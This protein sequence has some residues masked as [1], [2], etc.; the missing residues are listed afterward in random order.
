MFIVGGTAVGSTTSMAVR[1]HS[2]VF[3][4]C[5][6]GVLGFVP[7]RGGGARAAGRSVRGVSELRTER[8]SKGRTK[9]IRVHIWELFSDF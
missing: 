6:F 7:L 5:W 9:G 1:R 2:G 8:S 3:S 4:V